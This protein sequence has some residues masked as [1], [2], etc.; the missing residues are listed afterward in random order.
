MSYF[1]DTHLVRNFNFEPFYVFT[2]LQLFLAVFLCVN[3]YLH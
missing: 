2:A 1:Y 3:I